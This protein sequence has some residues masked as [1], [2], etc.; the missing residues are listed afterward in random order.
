VFNSSLS[1]FLYKQPLSTGKF[2]RDCKTLVE[3]FSILDYRLNIV[4]YSDNILECLASVPKN[5]EMTI[6]LNAI[7]RGASTHSPKLNP[8]NNSLGALD[9]NAPKQGKQYSFIKNWY[10]SRGCL[11]KSQTVF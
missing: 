6:P 10:Y 2:F 4:G 8:L 5:V 1:A 9:C 3:A 11:C 7:S